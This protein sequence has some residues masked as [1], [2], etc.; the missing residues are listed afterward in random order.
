MTLMRLL[1]RVILPKPV[2]YLQQAQR[3]R[4]MFA[5][6]CPTHAASKC[7]S[8]HRDW[9]AACNILSAPLPIQ[10]IYV[11]VRNPDFLFHDPGD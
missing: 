7:E 5:W 1:Y 9:W 10:E 6:S 8:Q 3:V 11:V 4:A 2:V